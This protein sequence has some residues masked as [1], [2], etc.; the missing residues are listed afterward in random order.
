MLREIYCM[1]AKMALEKDNEIM[2][3]GTT[4]ETPHTV[5]DML[6]EYDINMQKHES[7]GSL[8][9]IDSVQGYQ[10]ANFYGVFWLIEL[11]AIRAQKESKN[12]VFSI[13]DMGSFFLFGRKKSWLIMSFLYQRT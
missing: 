9:I 10:A 3:I 13:A 4:Y 2:L 1:F 6:R 12:G 11:L 7:N 8:V 5:R